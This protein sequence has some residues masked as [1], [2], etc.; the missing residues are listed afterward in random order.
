[1]LNEKVFETI[2]LNQSNMNCIFN[3]II[4]KFIKLFVYNTL[5]IILSIRKKSRLRNLTTLL[6]NIV[7]ENITSHILFGKLF[8]NQ[9]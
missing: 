3:L 7:V 5:I 9:L 2:F 6:E 1:M 8:Y 4:R